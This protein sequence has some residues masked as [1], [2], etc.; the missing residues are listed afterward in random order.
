M[1]QSRDARRTG[2]AKGQGAPRAAGALVPACAAPVLDFCLGVLARRGAGAGPLVLGLSG[3]QGAGKSTLAAWLTGA[4]AQRGWRAEAVSI[5]DFYLTHAQ[6]RALYQATGSRY[7]EH[8]GYPGTHDVALGERVLQGLV[9]GQGVR[10]PRY[11][12]SAHGG[13]GDRAPEAAWREVRGALDVVVLEGWLLGFVPVE[14]SEV[15]EDLE[16][17]NG[18]LAGYA[19]WHGLLGAFVHMEAQSLVQ[20]VAWRC[21]AE[22]ARRQAG[23][24]ALSEEE[25]RDYIERFLPAY[26]LY[27]PRL[28][29]RCPVAGPRLHVL[30]DAER[31]LVGAPEQF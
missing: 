4:L 25:A 19:A 16:L 14:P 23:E 8:R 11:D 10:V 26:G 12:K 15:G 21:A 17:P 20:I 27:V 7:L 31:G 30:L 9:A 13:R 1:S 5:D 24:A 18:Y 2:D 22:R 29:A 6:Q 3:P 28:R